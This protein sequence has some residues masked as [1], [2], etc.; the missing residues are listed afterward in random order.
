MC[1]V[2]NMQHHVIN[3]LNIFKYSVVVLQLN[4]DSGT[5]L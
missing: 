2:I 1:N 4:L 3:Y 5:K